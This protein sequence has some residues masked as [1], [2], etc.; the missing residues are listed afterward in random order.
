MPT[1]P[2]KETTDDITAADK[3][4]QMIAGLGDWRGR[5]LAEIRSL[6]HEI[7]PD[8]VEEWKWR[9]APVWSHRGMFAVAGAFK[10]KV[11][12][13]FHHGAQLADKHRLF[14]NG[15]DGNKW[16]AIDI[17]ETDDIDPAHFSDLLRE[18]MA[19]N[20]AHNVPKSKGSRAALLNK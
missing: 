4:D 3:I 10:N 2:G 14:N 20:D 19:Y 18:A 1:K 16:R 13:T 7:D 12:I 5:K 15:L 17:A 11:K 9:G 8:V 6:I